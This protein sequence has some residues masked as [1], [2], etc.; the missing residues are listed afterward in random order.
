MM[1]VSDV[2]DMFLPLQT[3]L[4]VDPVASKYDSVMARGVVVF[5]VVVVVV[6]V[7]VLAVVV[8]VIVAV[9]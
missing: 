6:V 7:E 8:V 9:I 4:A 2:D 1:V 5:V 3:G